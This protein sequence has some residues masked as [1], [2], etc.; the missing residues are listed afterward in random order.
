MGSSKPDPL[1]P[2]TLKSFLL[3]EGATFADLAKQR[4]SVDLEKLFFGQDGLQCSADDE[5]DDDG[6]DENKN[7][8]EEGKDGGVV[9]EE[10]EE[11]KKPKVWILINEKEKEKNP[12]CQAIVLW[13][14]WWWWLRCVCVLCVCVCI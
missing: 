8:V 4:Q 11:T 3:T 9:E 12:L 14:C 13:G 7:K 5:D 2:R 6:D 1:K 10:S